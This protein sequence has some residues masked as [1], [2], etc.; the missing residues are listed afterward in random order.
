M[1]PIES[2]YRSL[3]PTS[4]AVQ[5][6]AAQVMPGGDTRSSVFHPPYSLTI[7]R[8]AGSRM[9]DVDGNEYVDLNNNYTALVHGHAYPPIVKAAREAME[10]GSTWSGSRRP[11]RIPWM[12]SLASRANGSV[13]VTPRAPRRCRGRAWPCRTMPR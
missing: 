12:T 3:T 1:D 13:A 10:H 4:A 6:R 9:W 7:A 2:R 8:G 11:S 5:Q